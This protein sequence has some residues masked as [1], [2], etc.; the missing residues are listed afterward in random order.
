MKH[1]L[2]TNMCI[3]LMKNNP[4]V[5]NRY[6]K[7][8]KRGIAIS[9]ITV[10]ELYFGVYNSTNTIK[11]SENLSKFL[12]GVEIL[13][14]DNVAAIE[15]GRLRAILWKKGMPIGPL[16]ML[17]AAHAKSRNLVIVTNNVRE[18]KRIEDLTIE[19]WLS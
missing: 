16:D 12:I 9:S 3:F 5:V 15:Y 11:N 1:L 13:E 19:D 8:K 18:F 14:Y 10:A 17:I 2:D 6:K 7:N 4:S